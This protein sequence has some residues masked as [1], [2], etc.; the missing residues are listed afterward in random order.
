MNLFNPSND[1]ISDMDIPSSSYTG[2]STPLQPGITCA[3]EYIQP[4][5]SSLSTNTNS[6]SSSSIPSSIPSTTFNFSASSISSTTSFTIQNY[7]WIGFDLDHALARY[8]VQAL[9]R[10]IYASLAKALVEQCS[11]S[12]SIFLNHRPVPLSYL[13][14]K[15]TISNTHSSSTSSA[16]SRTGFTPYPNEQEWIQEWCNINTYD[17]TFLHKGLIFDFR[18]GDLLKLDSYGHIIIAYHGLY[19]LSTLQIRQRYGITEDGQNGIWKDFHLL[20]EQKRHEAAFVLITY[21]DLPAQLT[22]V[23]C[24]QALDEQYITNHTTENILVIPNNE[25]SSPFILPDI[26][27]CINRYLHLQ[28]DH[29]TVFNYIFDNVEAFES[30]RGGFFGT[31]KASPATYL[32]PRPE[33]AEYLRTLRLQHKKHIFLATNSHLQFATHALEF[34]LGKDWRTCFDII[35]FN[36]VKPAFFGRITPFHHP[37]NNRRSDGNIANHISIHL[38]YF[39]PTTSSS[40][41]TSHHHSNRSFSL[42]DLPIAPEF[43]QGNALTIQAIADATKWLETRGYQYLYPKNIINPDNDDVS[44]NSPLITRLTTHIDEKG[45]VLKI[46]AKAVPSEQHLHQIKSNPE[47]SSSISSILN[48][49]IIVPLPHSIHKGIKSHKEEDMSGTLTGKPAHIAAKESQPLS[50]PHNQV[51]TDDH[52]IPVAKHEASMIASQLLDELSTP[53]DIETGIPLEIGG[54]EGAHP[55]HARILYIGDHMH[56]DIVAAVRECEWDTVAIVEEIEISLPLTRKYT[57]TNLDY[58][59]IRSLITNEKNI[60]TNTLPNWNQDYVKLSPW[61]SFW[62]SGYKE[63]VQIENTILGKVKNQDTSSSTDMDIIDQYALQR[64]WFCALLQ[65]NAR[66]VIADADILIHL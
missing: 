21:F 17:P 47:S 56:G 8:N 44:I 16:S 18:T 65:S 55:G 4:L 51:H 14:T 45:H 34:I 50:S 24:V 33:L 40:D 54:A 26:S 22:L 23:Q 64:S 2:I 66:I 59:H 10:A 13:H 57:N 52:H 63:M 9:M 58:Q 43:C 38:P 42:H 1:K 29:I 31:I 5:L 15:S 6:L 36:S 19:P 61:G 48:R 39:L 12:R 28:K 35:I 32:I 62:T 41:T 49:E 11:Y 30:N 37:D 46:T 25:I 53:V 27:L 20:R 7:D 3:F 60:V